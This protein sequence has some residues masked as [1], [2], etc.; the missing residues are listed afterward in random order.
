MRHGNTDHREMRPLRRS[1]LLDF[2][3]HTGQKESGVG[4]G[5]EAQLAECLFSLQEALGLIS[6][7][8]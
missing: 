6:S 3:S 8:A 2:G 7:M 5:D 4:L 1:F